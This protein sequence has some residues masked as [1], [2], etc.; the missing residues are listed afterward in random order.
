MQHFLRN[1]ADK[2]T[3]QHRRF[4]RAATNPQHLTTLVALFSVS[5]TKT[6]QCVFIIYL[7]RSVSRRHLV[8]LIIQLAPN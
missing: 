6:Q 4:P 5:S 2:P 3:K 8:E 7:A 1:L